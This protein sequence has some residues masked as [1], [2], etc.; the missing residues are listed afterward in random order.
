[1]SGIMVMINGSPV[2]YKSR[3]QRV[4]VFSTTAV[5]YVAQSLCIQEVTWVQSLLEEL[6]FQKESAIIVY[7]D[8]QSAIAIIKN[9]GYQIRAKH[10][11]IRHHSVHETHIKSFACLLLII[12]SFLFRKTFKST[13]KV[14]YLPGL[15]FERKCNKA[16]SLT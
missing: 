15:A 10:I 12:L 6:G 3:L 4:V 5:E 13:Y 16:V 7:E 11:D 14:R 9:G 1:M 8:N 2:I